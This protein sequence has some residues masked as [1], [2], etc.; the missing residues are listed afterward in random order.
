MSPE[1]P[2][3]MAHPEIPWRLTAH[4]VALTRC[5]IPPDGKKVY[6]FKCKILTYVIVLHPVNLLLLV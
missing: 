4:Y 5:D 6:L 1:N 3:T 2:L